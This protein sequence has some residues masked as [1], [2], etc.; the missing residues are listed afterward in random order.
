MENT[1]L[2]KRLG[3]R[4]KQ[5]PLLFMV[6]FSTKSAEDPYK[7]VL[8]KYSVYDVGKGVMSGDSNVAVLNLLKSQFVDIII[9]AFII[10]RVETGICL[11]HTQYFFK[12]CR[13]YLFYCFYICSLDHNGFSRL[14]MH[15]C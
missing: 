9:E 10:V 13:E 11:D 4:I 1:P 15:Q 14:P 12:Y 6:E 2:R 8:D 7:R 5:R 3:E